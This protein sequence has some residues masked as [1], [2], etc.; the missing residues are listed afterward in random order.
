M[1]PPPTTLLLL[2]A[3][4]A[5][6][7]PPPPQASVALPVNARIE[8][9]GDPLRGAVLTSSYVFGQPASVAGNPAAA[10]EALAQLE[11]LTTELASGPRAVDFDALVVPMLA[12]GRAEARAAF[13]FSPAAPPQAAVNALYNAAEALRVNDRA[14]AGAALVP[15]TG[16]DRVEATLDRLAALPYLPAAAAATARARNSMDQRDRDRDRDRRSF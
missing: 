16:P 3:L 15:L 12:Q 2:L 4:G 8:G 5:C 7:A 11:Y 14:R 6:A 9:A 1:R 13:G 10:A